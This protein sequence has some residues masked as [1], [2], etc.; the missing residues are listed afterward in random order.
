M[1]ETLPKAFSRHLE[2]T[3]K[4]EKH[5]LGDETV[6]SNSLDTPKLVLR[7]CG[8]F[9]SHHLIITRDFFGIGHH[10]SCNAF[11]LIS[12]GISLQFLRGVCC[13]HCEVW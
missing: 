6:F 9:S 2:N 4:L 11:G 13:P 3:R 8:P 5:S 1:F 7:F 10:P 12:F